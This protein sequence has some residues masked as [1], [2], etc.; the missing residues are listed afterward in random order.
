MMMSFVLARACCGED[1]VHLMASSRQDRGSLFR[2]DL[3]K[4]GNHFTSSVTWILSTD[5]MEGARRRLGSD[6][7]QAQ[8]FRYTFTSFGALEMN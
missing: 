4:S 6:S 5:E 7:R 3:R 1:R 8:I 2:P